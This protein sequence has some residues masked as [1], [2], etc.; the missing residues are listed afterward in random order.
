M[1]FRLNNCIL[2]I[3]VDRTRA[4][5]GRPD[6][7]TVSEQCDC[8]NCRN[9][10]R[11]ILK[12]PEAVL[13]LLRSF[14]IDPRKPAEAFN[15]MGTAEADG[16]VWYNGW[17][18]VCGRVVEGSETVRETVTPDSTRHI[19]YLWNEAY[20]PDPDFPFALLSVEKADLLH[21]A[22]PTPAIELEIDTHLPWVLDMPLEG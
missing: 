2:D 9:F 6:V 14:G 3:D 1:I 13:S 19:A 22:F 10:E 7:P 12:A 17:Y 15:I 16:T 11:A 21:K 4:F 8:I 18:H 5:Y 20:T